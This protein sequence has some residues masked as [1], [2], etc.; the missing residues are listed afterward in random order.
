MASIATPL[1]SFGTGASVT[2]TQD[3]ITGIPTAITVTPAASHGLTYS[4]TC[5][6]VTQSG[7][8]QA[9]AAASVVAVVATAVLDVTQITLSST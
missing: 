7:T 1:A 2:I 3:S 5:K 9:G 6:G 4:I 8:V